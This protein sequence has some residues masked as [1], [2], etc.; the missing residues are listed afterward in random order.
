MRARACIYL[1]KWK[2]VFHVIKE[3]SVIVGRINEFLFFPRS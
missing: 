1:H 3:F 2:N